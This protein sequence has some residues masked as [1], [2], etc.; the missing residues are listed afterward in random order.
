M[1]DEKRTIEGYEVKTAIHI[2]G[3]EIIFA[4]NDDAAEP[5]MACNCTWDNP[6]SIGIYDSGVVSADYLEIMSEFLS[7]ASEQVKRIAAERDERGVTEV[8]LT[9]ADCV[10]GSNYA[11]YENQLIV[12]K[13]ESMTPAART[14]DNQLL[15][16]VNGNGCNPEARGQAVFC[17]HLFTGKTMRWDRQDVAG[18]I[19]PDRM[20]AW[21]KEKLGRP[22]PHQKNKKRMGRRYNPA[23]RHRKV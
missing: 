4:V 18:I 1:S 6:L 9:A 22:F 5:Y 3:R 16:A 11:H 13:P 23:P 19:R 8:P 12:I 10:P 20:P 17:K 7:R 15:L 2:G 14:A 21:A